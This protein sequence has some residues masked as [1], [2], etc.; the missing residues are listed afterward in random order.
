MQAPQ[1]ASTA[2]H[3][4]SAQLS[5][6]CTCSSCVLGALGLEALTTTQARKGSLQSQPLSLTGAAAHA[7][8]ALGSAWQG[9]AP[10]RAAPA[11]CRRKRRGRRGAVALFSTPRACALAT[12]LR[13]HSAAAL[14]SHAW[15]AAACA[16]SPGR[17][18]SPA[19]PFGTPKRASVDIVTGGRGAALRRQACKARP[20]CTTPPRGARPSTSAA[21][22]PR[23]SFQDVVTRERS[24]KPRQPARHA[25]PLGA[26]R[27]TEEQPCLLDVEK[28]RGVGHSIAQHSAA[29]EAVCD[30]VNS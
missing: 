1:R 26:A 14:S 2:R 29:Q 19:R 5:L 23:H 7:A 4:I 28:Q 25:R 8:Q 11:V 21:A 9:A 18:G 12:V 20:L 30:S 10:E 15:A 16:A 17:Q 6:P 27:C 22:Q 24:T 13:V 3:S